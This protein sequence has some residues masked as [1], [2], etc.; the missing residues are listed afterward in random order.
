MFLPLTDKTVTEP[1]N[2]LGKNNSIMKGVSSLD[3]RS[4]TFIIISALKSFVE[5]YKC[6][7][8]STEAEAQLAVHLKSQHED[9]KNMKIGN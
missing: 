3:F 2:R 1:T 7:I 4:D 8:D 5:H 9:K 6:D